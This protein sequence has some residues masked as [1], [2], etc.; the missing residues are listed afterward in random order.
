[1]G[2]LESETVIGSRTVV[3]VLSFSTTIHPN[4]ASRIE[5]LLSSQR[6]SERRKKCL[7]NQSRA[8]LRRRAL[9]Q[10][11]PGHRFPP[12]ALQ[13]QVQHQAQP[14]RPSARLRATHLRSG[15]SQRTPSN[16]ARPSD[17]GKTRE[18]RVFPQTPL[19]ALSEVS[20]DRKVAGAR[21][22]ERC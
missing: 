14:Q 3:L 21:P 7:N 1:M 12:A 17:L 19:F 20:R 15:V 11:K 5:A 22:R 16:Q 18:R 6:L 2:A 8:G 9:S 13:A 10:R 4:G